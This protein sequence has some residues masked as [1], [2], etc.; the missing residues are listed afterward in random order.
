MSRMSIRPIRIEGD[1]A[2]IPLTRGY[3]AVIDASDIH[4]VDG[5]HW[6]ACPDFR[7]D[8]TIRAVYAIRTDRTSPKPRSVSLHRVIAGTPPGFETDHID[9][10]GLNNRKANLRIATNVHNQH[11]QRLQSNNSSGVKGVSWHKATNK[12]AAHIGIA[13]RR[14]HLGLFSNLDDAAAAY[15]RASAELHGE[16]GRVK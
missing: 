14:K 4:L 10:D 11:N 15:A 16:F 8:G 7:R 12:W 9:G 13:R 3:E 2:Y 1:V 5:V 6:H